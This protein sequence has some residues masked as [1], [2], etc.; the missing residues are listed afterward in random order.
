MKREINIFAIKIVVCA[1]IAAFVHGLT[2]MFLGG[3]LPY[4]VPGILLAGGA[5]LGFIDRTPIEHGH[6]FKRGVAL[7]FGAVAVWLVAPQGQGAM[8][9]WQPY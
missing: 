3:S 2:F 4:L 9:P 6:F 1:A 8:I 7:L 5:Y